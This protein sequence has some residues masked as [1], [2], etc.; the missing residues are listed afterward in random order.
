MPVYS[1]ET[2][3]YNTDAIQTGIDDARD[4][5]KSVVTE[6][7]STGIKVHPTGTESDG[8]LIDDTGTDILLS[9]VSVA[10]Y[11]ETARIGKLSG[12]H[13]I[14][15][16]SGM[17]VF[18]DAQSVARFG[19]TARIGSTDGTYVEI[20]NDEISM[21]TD[22]K[23]WFDVDM[24]AGQCTSQVS[25]GG[26]GWD[27]HDT[28]SGIS[29]D[30]TQTSTL[31]VDGIPDGT[32]LTVN[33]PKMGVYTTLAGTAIQWRTSNGEAIGGRNTA[34]KSSAIFTPVDGYPITYVKGSSGTTKTS[35]ATVLAY[36]YMPLFG[37]S[38]RQTCT[39]TMT[40][41]YDGGAN[42]SITY[43]WQDS[44][45]SSSEVYM[46]EGYFRDPIVSGVYD[47]QGAAFTFGNRGV[48][49]VGP[50]TAT[51]GEG[52]VAESPEQFVIGKYNDPDKTSQFTVGD[53]TSDANRHTSL[54]IS[55]NGHVGLWDSDGNGGTFSA[56]H[57][58]TDDSGS[59]NLDARSGSKH[60]YFDLAADSSGTQAN[61]NVD[62]FYVGPNYVD[63]AA[64]I[65]RMVPYDGSNSS[66]DNHGANT[67]F[68]IDV[69]I[70]GKVGM[71][72][73][74][75]VACKLT[76]GPSSVSLRGFDLDGISFENSATVHTYWHTSDATTTTITAYVQ[77]MF[78][79]RSI[80]T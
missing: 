66:F 48:G 72:P 68:T 7:G 1:K 18:D 5:Y 43:R 80:Y 59:V 51:F 28:V 78:L 27:V 4:A 63:L 64:P 41:S 76:A 33:S 3:I 9:N 26:T 62:H 13:T 14:I 23:R 24:D 52:L 50:F 19:E 71:T 44:R 45:P 21:G 32:S 25:I 73:V 74:A 12:G 55:Q 61:L 15:D 37:E 67:N 17:E 36:R 11:G 29:H 20:G 31:S 69:T 53:G 22:S 47:V 10:K 16:Q 79:E 56:N 6:I 75:V 60:A 57:D 49:D 35:T 58:E 34:P 8:V 46:F 42:I 70:G 38:L 2:P 40:V 77:V 54:R 39:M 30:Y 65:V